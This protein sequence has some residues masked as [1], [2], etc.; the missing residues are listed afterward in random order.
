MSVDRFIRLCNEQALAANPRFAETSDHWGFE[1][2]T[3]SWVG[4][5]ATLTQSAVWS[6][7]A[8]P[9]HSL[10]L[11]S[12]GAA[13]TWSAS[14][15][16]GTS[17][18][19]CN[20]GDTVSAAADVF[21]PAALGNMALH[22]DFFNAAGTFLSSISP[23][24]VAVAAGD[25]T[26]LKATGTIPAAAAFLACIVLDV[27]T[28]AAGKLIYVDHVRLTPRMGPQT[29]KEYHHFLH[30]I[31]VLDAGILTEARNSWALGLRTR[32]S[33]VAQAAA[34]TLTYNMLSPPLEPVVDDQRTVNDVI[35]HRHKGSR[36][37]I[38]NTDTNSPMNVNVPPVGIDKK[39]SITKVIAESD[40]QL[41]RLAQ[42]LLNLGT[43]TDERY[44]TITVNLARA[45]ITGNA[46]A[47]LLPA[48]AA[49]EVGDRVALSGLPPWFPSTTASQLV[50]GYTETIGPRD[51]EI[52]W[53]AVPE[54]PYSLTATTS[55]R[56]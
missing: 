29:A 36:V 51:W 55:G 3:Q 6:S 13:G 28:V 32:F 17:G 5:L 48:I 10:L 39:T 12:T 26:T 8:D 54:S 46:M 16:R 23:A 1:T 7:P 42:H 40:A 44:P 2:G 37:R 30:E 22:I 52:V 49:V 25:V 14:S 34:V 33:L 15:P 11:T 38:T 27:E 56:W 43:V 21:T 20:P 19:P 4:T 53:N 47:P 9:T 35:L 50:I 45:S 18:R 24:T 41:L 31:A